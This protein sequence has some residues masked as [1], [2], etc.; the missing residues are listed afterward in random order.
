MPQ[1]FKPLSVCFDGP[2]W[3][4]KSTFMTWI[5]IPAR[6]SLRHTPRVSLITLPSKAQE[7]LDWEMRDPWQIVTNAL[8]VRDEP[9]PVY[10]LINRD[11]CFIQWKVTS[12][13][14]KPTVD[15]VLCIVW[16]SMNVV[17]SV[18]F[19][20]SSFIQSANTNIER[21]PIFDRYFYR[22]NH[23]I[24]TVLACEA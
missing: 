12:A 4:Y 20:M 22:L 3:I 21:K 7:A 1:A 24:I 16:M 23:I 18:H 2:F 15:C 19:Q 6:W 9:Q 10:F 17:S 5:R 11:I 13:Q 8:L 14:Q